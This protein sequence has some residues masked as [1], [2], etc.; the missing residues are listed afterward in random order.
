MK[1]QGH[2]S[3]YYVYIL[4]SPSRT[5]YTGVT[6]DL[7]RRVSEH[8][9]GTGRSF[10]SRYRITQLVH[11]EQFDDILAAIEREKRIKGLLRSKKVALVE[12]S[13]PLWKDLGADWS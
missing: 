12:S 13:N 8:R 2:L 1:T 5:L 11:F 6:D 7:V 9:S 4:A 3:G 10:T